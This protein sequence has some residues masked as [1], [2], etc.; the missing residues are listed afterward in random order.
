MRY[1]LCGL[2]FFGRLLALDQS[3]APPKISYAPANFY[4]EGIVY[5]YAAGA[6]SL[7][8]AAAHSAINHKFLAVKVRIY[9]MSEK[10]VTVKPADIVVEDAVN[11]RL[12]TAVAGADLANR[13]RRA[14]NTARYAVGS[15]PGDGQDSPVMGDMTGAQFMAMMRAM[16]ARTNSAGSSIAGKSVLYTDTQGA[17]D[18]H[19]VE[20]PPLAECDQVCHLRNR[21]TDGVDA[22]AQLQRQNSPEYVEQC[23]FRA[24]TI[25]PRANTVGVLYYPFS[26]LAESRNTGESKKSREVRVTVNVNGESFVFELPVQ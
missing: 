8:V 20:A 6:D 23:S 19:N 26:K 4:V 12:L 25:P 11:A 24:N 18:P 5:Q 13:M 14:Y 1:L 3:A 21:E 7:V 22:L 17:L 16:A 9:N 10:S 2:L 15:S